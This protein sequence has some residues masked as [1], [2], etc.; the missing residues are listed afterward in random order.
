MHSIYLFSVIFYTVRFSRLR[1]Y[2]RKI[3]QYAE[4]HSPHCSLVLIDLNSPSMPWGPSYYV[5]L[6]IEGDG[7]YQ[8]RGEDTACRRHFR[9]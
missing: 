4:A 8:R 9:V 6:F 5:E 7:I 1:F 3:I 2:C